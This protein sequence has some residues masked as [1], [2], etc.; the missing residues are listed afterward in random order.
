M[1]DMTWLYETCLVHVRH[2]S[3]MWDMTRSCETWLVHVRHDSFMWDMPHS[4]VTWL[5]QV[6]KLIHVRHDWFIDY[7]LGSKSCSI[8][9]PSGGMP[10]S[11][12]TWLVHVRRDSSMWDMPLS[13]VTW[14]VHMTW[15]VRV[16]HDWF[17]DTLLG[18]SGFLIVF[19]NESCHT[20]Q[21]QISH[22]KH[23]VWVWCDVM[24]CAVLCCA[25]LWCAVMWCDVM[26][27]VLM[28]CDVI[29]S[30]ETRVSLVCE[31]LYARMSHVTHTKKEWVMSHTPRM[32]ECRSCETRVVY[33]RHDSFMGDRSLTYMRDMTPSCICIY[34]YDIYIFV[35]YICMSFLDREPC[36][37]WDMSHMR[38]IQTQNHVI[39]SFIRMP[40]TLST[41]NATPPKSTRSRNSDS[42]KSR[43]TNSNRDCGLIWI[44]TEE[45]ESLDVV[46][47]GGV[48]FSVDTVISPWSLVEHDMTHSERRRENECAC[49]RASLELE[50]SSCCTSRVS[51]NTK[52]TPGKPLILEMHARRQVL[53]ARLEREAPC[54]C[55]LSRSLF[56]FAT[57]RCV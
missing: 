2:D 10:R 33:V 36:L 3:F 9:L 12:E 42:S 31:T 38:Q 1:W 23:L 45:F 20:H 24:C 30:C 55:T 4:R 29:R 13:R 53:A 18:T 43:G 19:M 56:R 48:A 5:I 28:Q 54:C 17:I 44:C 22:V 32:N 27:C 47:F 11:C 52:A 51:G 8:V 50:A 7:L 49:V 41:E 34:I 6:T 14:L 25:V 16:E 40:M 21:G 57:R 37:I 46:D 26:W 35:S 39:S 15:L